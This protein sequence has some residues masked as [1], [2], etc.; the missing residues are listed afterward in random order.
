MVYLIFALIAVIAG[1]VITKIEFE[2][3][4]QFKK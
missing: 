1:Y 2:H 3:Y 4:V